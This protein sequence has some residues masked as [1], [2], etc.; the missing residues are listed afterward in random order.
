MSDLSPPAPAPS[1]TEFA[2]FYLYGL[3]DNP[4][5]QSTD[6]QHFGELYNLV[7][8]EHGGV[9]LS[10]SFHPYQLVNPAGVTV[11]YAAYAQLYAQPNRADLFGAMADEQA[12]FVVAPPASFGQFHVWPDTRLTSAE[13]PVFSRYIPFVLPFLVRKGPAALR[14]DAEFAAAGGDPERIQPYLE[15]VTEA[16]RFVQPAPAF[17]LGFGE[18]DEQQPERLIE[19]FMSCRAM[20]P[21]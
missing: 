5:Q 13:N 7:I 17:V 18:F 14:W 11:W 16:I 6:M 10:S 1:L 2:S 12:R 9:S 20:L 4:Y 8:G 19:E 21:A 3:T 15:A